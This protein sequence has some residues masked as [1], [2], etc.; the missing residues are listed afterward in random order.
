MDCTPRSKAILEAALSWLWD[1]NDL[2]SKAHESISAQTSSSADTAASVSPNC[3]TPLLLRHTAA[4][5]ISL[6]PN[7]GSSKSLTERWASASARQQHFLNM[8]R[9]ELA[10]VDGLAV[11]QLRNAWLELGRI[12]AEKTQR[13]HIYTEPL[14]KKPRALQAATNAFWQERLGKHGL[15][16]SSIAKDQAVRAFLS[17]VEDI[18]PFGRNA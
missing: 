2:F 18:G 14:A 6:G 12:A 3:K 4:Q 8:L 15:P 11:C 10:E 17:K 1:L 7:V 5:S 13:K 9:E 16:K